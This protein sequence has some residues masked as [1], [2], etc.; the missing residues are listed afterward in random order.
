[1]NI[2]A[3]PPRSFGRST[4]VKPTQEGILQDY[5]AIAAY[6]STICCEEPTNKIIFMGHSLGAS[7]ATVLIASSHPECSFRCDGLIFE[8]GFSSIPDMVR[9]L[10]PHKALP[11]HYLGPLV[12]DR[13][14]AKTALRQSSGPTSLLAKIPIL[15]VSSSNDELV[16]PKMMR[17]LYE[18]AM[19]ARSLASESRIGDSSADAD[20]NI[21]GIQWLDV[22]GGLHDFAWKKPLW[23]RTIWTWLSSLSR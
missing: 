13:W 17:E 10:Y 3:I 5:G 19:E 7:I 2:I 20:Q 8:N 6:V 4:R 11:Y 21:D 16:P 23:S 15:F 14:D 12:L 22:H 18:T 1:M 9:A